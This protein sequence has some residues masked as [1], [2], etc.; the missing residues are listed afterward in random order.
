LFKL[1]RSNIVTKRKIKKHDGWDFPT[2]DKLT[3]KIGSVKITTQTKILLVVTE[4]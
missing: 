4:K 2:H 1:S 3:D